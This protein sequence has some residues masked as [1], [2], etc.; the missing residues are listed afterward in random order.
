[1]NEVNLAS[2]NDVKKAGEMRNRLEQAGI[3]AE[4]YDESNWKMKPIYLAGR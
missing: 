3:H 4:V 2:F 1:M